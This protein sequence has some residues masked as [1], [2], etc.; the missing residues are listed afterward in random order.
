[1]KQ[2]KTKT[3]WEVMPK[4]GVST[5]ECGFNPMKHEVTCNG[6]ENAEYITQLKQG[7]P[8][9][10]DHI[11]DGDNHIRMIKDVLKNTFPEADGPQAKVVDPGL[12]RLRYPQP[13]WKVGRDGRCHHRRGRQ[14][15]FREYPYSRQRA[16]AV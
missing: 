9:R 2:C 8:T 1:M 3:E 16:G 12:S 10:D 5:R 4:N 6:S 13:E 14:H 11:S 7:N 15:R